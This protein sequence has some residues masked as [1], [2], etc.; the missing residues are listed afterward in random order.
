MWQPIFCCLRL[1][2]LNLTPSYG[3]TEME[4]YGYPGGLRLSRIAAS[5]STT[6]P[7]PAD[8][9]DNDCDGRVDE[10]LLNGIDD[11]DDGLIDED[12][13]IGNCADHR[14]QYRMCLLER[15]RNLVP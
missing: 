3:F 4:S 13:A 7:V 5:C 15:C 6:T 8:R 1:S 11:D 2:I 14:D 9:V 10:E 12:L